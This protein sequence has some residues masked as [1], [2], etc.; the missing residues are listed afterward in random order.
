MISKADLVGDI[1][2]RQK[3]EQFGIRTRDPLNHPD[4]EAIAK[5]RS[6][7]ENSIENWD[8]GDFQGFDDLQFRNASNTTIGSAQPHHRESISSRMSTRSDRESNAGGDEDWQVLLAPESEDATQK[9]IVSAKTAGIPIPQ[10]VPTSALLGGTIKRLGGRRIKKILGDDWEDDLELP[11]LRDGGL[12]LKKNDENDFDD[13]MRQFSAEFPSSPSPKK[14]IPGKSFAERMASAPKPSLGASP[15]DKFKDDD[16]DDFFGDVPTIKIAKNRS[17]QKPVLFNPPPAKRDKLSTKQIDNIDDD[18]ELPEDGKPLR[19]STQREAPKTPMQQSDD[20]DIEWAEGSLGTRF[21]GTGRGARSIPSSSVSAFS[22][23][24]SSRLTGGESED[25]GLDDLILPD[26]PFK[27]DQALKKTLETAALVSTDTPSQK[28]SSRSPI[29]EDPVGKDD[30]FT[31]IDIGD[32]D[33]FDSGKL[34]L[35]RNIKQKITRKTSPVRRPATTLTFTN[36]LETGVS[37]IPRLQAQDRGRSNLEPV[38]ESGDPIPFHRRPGSRMAGHSSQSSVSAIPTPSTPS[39]HHAAV[40]STPSRRG[41]TPSA[42]RDTLKTQAVT[43][44]GPILRSKRSMPVMGRAQP[45]PARAPSRAGEYGRQGLPSRPKTPVDRSGAESSLGRKPPVPFLPAGTSSSQSHH[46]SA[47]NSRHFGRPTSS[48]SNENAPINRPVSRLSTSQRPTTPLFRRDHAPEAL[49]REAASKRTLTRP[50]RRRAFGDGNELEIFDDLPTSASSEAKYLKQPSSRGTLRSTL[51]RSKL[52]IMQH[53]NRS[54]ASLNDHFQAPQTPS[55]PHSPTKQDHV[56][57]F[58]RD[59]NASRMAREQRI[60]SVSATLHNARSLPTVRE[61]GGPLSSISTNSNKPGPP[62]SAKHLASPMPHSKNRSKHK[63]PQK[64]RLI[65]PMN[66]G[67]V[68]STKTLNGMSWNPKLYRWEGNE[69]ALAP[70]DVPVC[71]PGLSTPKSPSI[72]K[73]PALIANVG[74]NKGVQMS[75][76]MVFDPQRMRWLKMVPTGPTRTKGS[77]SHPLSPDTIEDEED[78][79]AGIEDLEDGP[80]KSNKQSGSTQKTADTDVF[81]GRLDRA[82][83]PKKILLEEDD[84]PV[85]EEFDVG[86]EFIRRQRAEEE[87]WRN[88]VAGWVGESVKRDDNAGKS[89]KW[90][91]REKAMMM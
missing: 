40:P 22:P 18:F 56:P 25:E 26:G 20:L 9:A 2:H 64:P 59:T 60:G 6:P 11:K 35:N 81:G 78:P 85:Q 61:A 16:P 43:T 31:G 88:K 34:T 14:Q 70:F 4:M 38:S 71:G 42:S 66:E 54:T 46:V 63:V 37:R 29:K 8:D 30:F 55:T 5:G 21:G 10:N 87:R 68:N 48:D 19:L 89:W 77:S 69:N 13:S 50:T 72:G 57:H 27:F 7:A 75:G 12:K 76:G 32:G 62:S 45:S 41:L 65:K 44:N 83:G 52:G 80:A 73:T 23:S 58:A 51:S 86:P 24:A 28:S 1:T 3:S 91:I 84:M 90:A 33:V 67:A 17:P 53:S 36:R 79:F 47:R 39:S 15:L 74:M 82:P 49:A